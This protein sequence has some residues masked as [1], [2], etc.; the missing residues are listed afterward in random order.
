MSNKSTTTFW[1]L[2]PWEIADIVFSFQSHFPSIH[3]FL[4]WEKEKDNT[5]NLNLQQ[6]LQLWWVTEHYFVDKET[7]GQ[8]KYIW[9]SKIT[10]IVYWYWL[11]FVAKC[12]HIGKI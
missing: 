9:A 5:E 10:S 12:E 3:T 2:S 6:Y 11:N 1:N 8:M 4:R 7:K